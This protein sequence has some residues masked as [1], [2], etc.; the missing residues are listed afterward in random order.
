MTERKQ[1]QHFSALLNDYF[2]RLGCENNTAMLHVLQ[3]AFAAKN[4]EAKVSGSRISEL[5]NGTT[6]ISFYKKVFAALDIAENGDKRM[7]CVFA[8]GLWSSPILL[9]ALKKTSSYLLLE[10]IKFAAY[11]DNETDE[12]VWNQPGEPLPPFNEHK[13]SYFYSGEVRNYVREGVADFG[14]LG[15][16][17]SAD[18]KNLLR[19][20]RIVNGEKTRHRIAFISRKEGISLK[21]DAEFVEKIKNDLLSLSS[22]DTDKKIKLLYLNRSTAEK[23]YQD[24][25]QRFEH[26]TGR[27]DILNA[28]TMKLQ[29]GEELRKKLKNKDRGALAVI[30]LRLS[31]KIV[32]KFILESEEFKDKFQVTIINTKDLYDLAVQK[33]IKTSKQPFLYD[34]VMLN[35]NEKLNQM[36]KFVE[37][38]TFLRELSSMIDDITGVNKTDG[39]PDLHK[40]VAQF[41][42]LEN[43]ETSEE[44]REITFDLLFYQE[45]MDKMLK[46]IR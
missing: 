8:Q 32:E 41:Y 1:K 4:I 25:M 21:N 34:M 23:E 42:S 9:L 7:G 18:D 39:I 12:I 13:H 24:L 26:E 45:F 28:K 19:I 43:K 20:C 22:K 11:K 40:T 27:I 17:V 14:F 36:E 10:H 30:G 46:L 15:S 16:L 6:T 38:K 33:N 37:V 29:L 44:L 5:L 31:S 2:E 35:N 3:N